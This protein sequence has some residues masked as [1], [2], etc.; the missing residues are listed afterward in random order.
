VPLPHGQVLTTVEHTLVANGY[1]VTDMRLGVSSD[2]CRFFGTLDLSFRLIDGVTLAVGVRNSTDKTF[3]LGFCSG[4]RVFVCDNLAFRSELLVRTKHTRF[5]QERFMTAIC[6]AVQR[7]QNF[8]AS[9]VFRLEQAR[10]TRLTEH[11]A[12][13]LGILTVIRTGLREE[14]LI[15][16]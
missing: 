8:Q 14:K 12:E 16:A 10:S 11:Q 2:Q 3:P 4:S 5:G 7:L 13:S 1:L 6:A 15:A 9:E